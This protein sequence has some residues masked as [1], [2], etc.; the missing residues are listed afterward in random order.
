MKLLTFD[1]GF[2]VTG[3]E[4]PERCM[5][6]GYGDS[7]GPLVCRHPDTGRWTHIGAVSWGTD[8]QP[9]GYTPGVYANT[10]SLRQWIVDTMEANS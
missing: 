10:I 1:P 3:D 6:T 7:G 9:D 8:C 5:T 4:D 2:H